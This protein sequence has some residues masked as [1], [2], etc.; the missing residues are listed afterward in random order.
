MRTCFESK[1]FLSKSCPELSNQESVFQLVIFV[2]SF[3][4]I[5]CAP[6]STFCHQAV[7]FGYNKWLLIQF[8]N[9]IFPFW[10]HMGKIKNRYIYFFQHFLKSFL[11]DITLKMKNNIDF[12]EINELT[13][14]F[15]SP[16]FH[17][18]GK[19]PFLKW[20]ENHLEY[21]NLTTMSKSWK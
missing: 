14:F 3:D 13:I 9:V 6:F 12:F 4:F 7:K 1:K 8:H 17:Q 10:W 2:S 11:L 20:L 18:N 15:I 21:L 5:Y 16:I 19:T